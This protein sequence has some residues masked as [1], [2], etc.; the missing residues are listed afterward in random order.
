MTFYTIGKTLNCMNKVIEAIFQRRHIF[1]H[2]A[3]LPRSSLSVGAP[4]ERKKR[5]GGERR[6]KELFPPSFPGSLGRAAKAEGERKRASEKEQQQ[7]EEGRGETRSDSSFCPAR[8]PG[9]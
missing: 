8:R 3:W 1:R 4:K 5:P 6:R 2:S 7:E 9:R